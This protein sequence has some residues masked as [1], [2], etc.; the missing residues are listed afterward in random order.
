M[1]GSAD[2]SWVASAVWRALWV[3]LAGLVDGCGRFTPGVKALMI[4]IPWFF[5]DTQA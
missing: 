4:W 2:G 1:V 3:R 5:D